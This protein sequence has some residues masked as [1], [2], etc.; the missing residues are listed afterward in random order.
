[1]TGDFFLTNWL[2]LGMRWIYETL[3]TY[4]GM[5]AGFTI[6]WTILLSTLTIKGLTLFSDIKSRKSQ[7]KMQ[8][9]QPDLDKLKKKYA[10]DARKLNEEQR[11]FMKERGVSS[12]G[13]CVPMLFTMPL[14]IMFIAAFRI[15]SNEQMLRLMLQLETNPEAG[16]EMFSSYKFLW[17]NNIWRPDNISSS[18]IMTGEEFW[19]TFS[20]GKGFLSAAIEPQKFFFFTE[21]A[22]QLSALLL[23]MGFYVRDSSGALQ[24]AADNALFLKCYDQLVAPCQELYTGYVNGWAALPILAGGTS[25]LSSWVMMRNQP[26]PAEGQPNTGKSMMYIGP[27]MSVFFCWSSAAT[28]ALYWTFSNVITMLIS[29]GINYSLKKKSK[30]VEVL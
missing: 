23:K 11:K 25:F 28:F 26:A 9:I 24:I 30:Q 14:F 20:A 16:V 10:K 15:W 13:G 29:M 7:I 12:F 17:I 8:E 5:Q 2:F 19:R 21:N 22:D 6:F 4:A 1:M 3:Q 18:V 27:I